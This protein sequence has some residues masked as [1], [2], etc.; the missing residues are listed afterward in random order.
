MKER[1]VV[2]QS[3]DSNTANIK[4]ILFINKFFNSRYV[5]T[6]NAGGKVNFWQIRNFDVR[7]II[8]YVFE[9]SFKN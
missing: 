6:C 9:P 4:S 3:A 1:T 5:M 7:N 8:S 2:Y